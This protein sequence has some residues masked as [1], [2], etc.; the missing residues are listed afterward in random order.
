[1]LH[2]QLNWHGSGKAERLGDARF[3]T[4][5]LGES[6]YRSDV[7]NKRLF[8]AG[9][10]L[11]RAIP[12]YIIAISGEPGY[13]TQPPADVAALIGTIPIVLQVTEDFLDRVACLPRWALCQHANFVQDDR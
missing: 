4:A 7:P 8:L 12:A 1:L 5:G 10:Q 13:V 11:P 3:W 9:V 6:E 2:N